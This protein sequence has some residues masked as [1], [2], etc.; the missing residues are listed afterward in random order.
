MPEN[1]LENLNVPK[2]ITK[3]AVETRLPKPLRAELER[4]FDSDFS[5]IKV[6]QSHL[7]TLNGSD[8]FVRGNELHFAPGRFDPHS[9]AGRHLIGHELS[10][11]VQQR[12]GRVRSSDNDSNDNDR[13]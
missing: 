8:T 13:N 1:P 4:A 2:Q 9:N 12:Q 6:M 11:V 7:P 5:N 3:G 10:H